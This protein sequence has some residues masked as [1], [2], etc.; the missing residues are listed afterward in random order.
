MAVEKINIRNEIKSMKFLDERKYTQHCYKSGYISIEAVELYNSAL[1]KAQREGED[2]AIIELKR[3][4]TANENF[5]EAL[6][7]LGMCY[8]LAKNNDEAN[9][10]L[11]KAADLGEYGIRAYIL[12]HM[13]G[14]LGDSEEETDLNI[15]NIVSD[16]KGKRAA[17]NVNDKPRIITKGDITKNGMPENSKLNTVKIA[18]RR[19]LEKIK[20]LFGR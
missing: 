18:L 13:T 9:K 2:I 8:I 19:M 4:L 6:T 17:R 3:A 16:V 14:V 15:N 1:E 7:L 5:I 10:C 20:G 12:L 11:L